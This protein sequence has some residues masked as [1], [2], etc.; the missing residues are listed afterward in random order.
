MIS[1]MAARDMEVDL[2]QAAPTLPQLMPLM[3]GPHAWY[4]RNFVCTKGHH[5]P[6]MSQEQNEPAKTRYCEFCGVVL[7][8]TQELTAEPPTTGGRILTSQGW[9]LH[10]VDCAVQGRHLAREDN[11]PFTIPCQK[12]TNRDWGEPVGKCECRLPANHT[13][14]CAE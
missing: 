13:R 9:N 6:V 2:T 14:E 4:R 7:G 5:K 10:D 3:S 11:S 1:N 8:G 12:L